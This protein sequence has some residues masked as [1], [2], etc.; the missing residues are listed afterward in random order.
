MRSSI[1]PRTLTPDF[2]FLTDLSGEALP[3]RIHFGSGNFI[4]LRTVN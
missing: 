2:C 1:K 3:T 4:K